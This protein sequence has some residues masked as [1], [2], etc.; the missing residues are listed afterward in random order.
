MTSS[1]L[2]NLRLEQLTRTIPD[3]VD[4]TYTSKGEATLV[5][6]HRIVSDVMEFLRDHSL[7]RMKVIVDIS[8][9]D[10]PSRENRFDVVYSML[11]IAFNNRL[12]VKTLVADG[13]P[14][15][16]VTRL[17]SAAN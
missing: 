13:Q 17:F 12:R 7:T 10:Y 16:S 14:V 15:E 4:V 6:D 9:T 8:G 5:V 11:S 1:K 2:T 3:A